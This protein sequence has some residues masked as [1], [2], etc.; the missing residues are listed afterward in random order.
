MR[1]GFLL[2]EDAEFSDSG[3]SAFSV[4]ISRIGV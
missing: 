2:G 1:V 3:D 4:G